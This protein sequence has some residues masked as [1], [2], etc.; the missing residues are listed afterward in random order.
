[1]S[2]AHQVAYWKHHAR[3]HEARANAAPDSAELERLRAADAELT[4]RKTAELSETERLQK[5]RD[6]A[7]A[8]AAAERARTEAAT[9]SALRLQVAADKGLTP[10]QATRLQG[11]T[12]EE[13]EADAD[14]LL[15]AFGPVTPAPGTPRSGGPRGSDAGGGATTTATG[16]ELYRQRHGKN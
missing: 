2:T 7:L 13:L 6:D 5:E 1:M 8:E 12:K 15:S 4:T 11:A 14:E 9:A 3:K 10:A 16:A